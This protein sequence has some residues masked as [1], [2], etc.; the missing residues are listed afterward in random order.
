MPRLNE[1]IISEINSIP[2]KDVRDFLKWL[3][4]FEREH[5]DKARFSYKTEINSYL[6]EM[7]EEKITEQDNV[8]D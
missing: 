2:E 1:N 6:E 7:I 3:V 5:S 8:E 4:E